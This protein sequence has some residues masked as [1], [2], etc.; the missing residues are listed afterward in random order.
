M[1][2]QRSRVASGSFANV[3]QMVLGFIV[4]VAFSRHLGSAE[5][6][7]YFFVLSIVAT[8]DGGINGI[9]AALKKRISEQ[10]ANRDE[11]L[12]ALGIILIPIS[13]TF[14]ILIFVGM[15][16]L[17]GNWDPRVPQLV[18]ILFA[19]FV[20][21]TS[22]TRMIIGI[23]EVGKAKWLQTSRTAFRAVVQ[24]ALI[25]L[26]TTG[27]VIGNTI[28]I[29]VFL[30]IGLFVLGIYPS[31]PSRETLRLIWE[32]ARYS[33]PSGIVGRLNDSTDQMIIGLLF[34]SSTVGLYGVAARLVAPAL[35]I[36]SVIQGSLET[37]VS[38]L[39]SGGHEVKKA[40]RENM[41]FTAILSIPL[42][43]GSLAIGDHII[44]VIFGDEFTGAYLFL[45]V[46]A[47]SRVV[48]SLASPMTSIIGSLDCPSVVF[49]INLASS[50]VLLVGCFGMGIAI[51][52]VG[53]AL[54]IVAAIM[55]R[56]VLCVN[57]LHPRVG[58]KNLVTR[59][60]F[61]QVGA[62]FI[63][64]IITYAWDQSTVV[65]G[66]METGILIGIGG[67]VYFLVLLTMSPEFRDLARGVTEDFYSSSM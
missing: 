1:A 23:S 43:F 17:N 12:G 67:V 28:G 45:V 30:V 22:I 4:V 60:F 32:Y 41:S 62:G 38:N 15:S 14:S 64:L 63:M 42:F 65:T 33:I 47:F 56:F 21:A 19:P 26:G 44:A 55:T 36:T 8:L 58:I 9:I 51:G 2:S 52:G 40:I 13:I 31:I 57:F 5:I 39:H 20:I 61:E 66:W 3:V 24:F 25:G 54:G 53:V 18:A 59:Q 10:D 11:I 37:K 6:G 46:L 50:M 49:R 34:V 29:V 48:K 35:L 27:L 16:A 7:V